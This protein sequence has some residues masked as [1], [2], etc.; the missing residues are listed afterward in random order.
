MSKANTSGNSLAYEL[1]G[2]TKFDG[3]TGPLTFGSD[4]VLRRPVFVVR[5]QRGDTSLAMKIDP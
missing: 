1:R 4:Q 2:L 5:C 3:V